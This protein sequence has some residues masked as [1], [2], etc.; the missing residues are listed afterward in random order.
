MSLK[1]KCFTMGKIL[2]VEMVLSAILIFAAAFIVL[3]MTPTDQTITYFIIGIYALSSFAGGFTAGKAMGKQKFLWGF[4]AGALY[5]LLIVIIAFAVKGNI[6]SGSI[7]LVKMIVPSLIGG[8][9][10]GMIS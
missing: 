5:V 1:K 9:F 3:K 10:G 4:L 6:T 2:L 7:G 8:T